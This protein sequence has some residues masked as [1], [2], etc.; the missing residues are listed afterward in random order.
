MSYSANPLVF[1]SF[2][3]YLTYLTLYLFYLRY[4]FIFQNIL[5]FFISGILYLIPISSSYSV[6]ALCVVLH[7]CSMDILSFFLF[8]YSL[9]SSVFFFFQIVLVYAL[10]LLPTSVLRVWFLIVY[11]VLSL[12]HGIC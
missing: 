9:P 3:S 6:T 12:S 8:F 10:F 7:S 2:C 1:I 5:L 11:L 4:Y